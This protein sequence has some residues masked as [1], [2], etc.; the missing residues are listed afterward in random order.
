[1]IITYRNPLDPKQTLDVHFDI[2]QNEFTSRW[3]EELKNLLKADFH[4]EKLLF[5]GIC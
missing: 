1:M 4:I 3:K 2:Y 5:Y